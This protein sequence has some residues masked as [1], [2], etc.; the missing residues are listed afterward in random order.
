MIAWT[1]RIEILGERQIIE[2]FKGTIYFLRKI[3]TK[4]SSD[5]TVRYARG[6]GKIAFLDSGVLYDLKNQLMVIMYLKALPLG[7]ACCARKGRLM[8]PRKGH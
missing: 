7:K 6:I 8:P 1:E 2:P 3:S 4:R 5:Q